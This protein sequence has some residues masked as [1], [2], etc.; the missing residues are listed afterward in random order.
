MICPKCGAVYGETATF[1]AD[2]GTQLEAENST[3]PTGQA[4]AAQ[5]S[6]G[7]QP[8][9]PITVSQEDIAQIR[10]YRGPAEI[11]P[12]LS[13]DQTNAL[14]AHW[15]KIGLIAFVVSLLVAF[16]L[17]T[18][19]S[20][21]MAET[22]SAHEADIAEKRMVQLDTSYPSFDD[23]T[24]TITLE[25]TNESNSDFSVTLVGEVSRSDSES[26]YDLGYCFK[27][28]DDSSILR[29]HDLTFTVPANSTTTCTL[30]LDE[31]GP[32]IEPE[33]G[34]IEVEIGDLSP[35]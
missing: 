26:A 9:A 6:R 2:C 19:T 12:P 7:P 25:V 21:Q 28:M 16:G 5:T 8:P 30:Q 34:D 24:N 27:F 3:Q 11:N 17:A 33:S 18:C 4:A 35:I 23:T 32:D 15:R 31:Y 20:S 10:S 14:V 1:C 22:S 13:E 29:P